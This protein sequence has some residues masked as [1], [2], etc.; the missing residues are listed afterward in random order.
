MITVFYSGD[1]F[2]PKAVIPLGVILLWDSPFALI[3]YMLFIP[4][5]SEEKVMYLPSGEN[6]GSNSVTFWR[7]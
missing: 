7:P 5:W 4:S 2:G 3:I 6:E 1:Q